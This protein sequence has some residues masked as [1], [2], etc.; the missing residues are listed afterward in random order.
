MGNISLHPRLNS[1]GARLGQYNGVETALSFDDPS[2]ELAA[3]RTQC[4]VFDLSWRAKITVAGKD[5]V[6]WLHNMVT[7]NVRDL[8]LNRGNYNF[9]L[10]VQGRI[11]GDM[12]IYNRGEALLLDTDRTQVATLLTAMKRFI[13]MD[14]VEMTDSSDTF[15]AVGL[16][17]P[18]TEEMLAA[19]GIDAKGLQPLEVRDIT[20]SGLDGNHLLVKGPENKRDWYEIWLS[21]A[22]AQGIWDKLVHAGAQPVGAAALEMWRVMHGIPHYGQDIRDRDLPQETE[23][24]RAL[25]FNK[26]CYIGQE[27][28][29]RIRSRGQVHRK[30]TGFEFEAGLPALGKYESEGRTLAEVTSTARVS[31]S[32]GEKN[33]GL[34]YVRREAAPAGS[35]VDL[36]GHAARIVN[37]P[38][39]I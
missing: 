3:L 15:Q 29:E 7:N 31:V 32:G 6:R 12:Y 13:I 16:C 28:V 20:L 10:N 21:E 19:A 27:I 36:N 4:G 39:D 34:G 30:F 22:N 33:I 35:Q 26:G 23:Q 17:G 38:F 8:A 5:R 11:L 1:P 18:K 2:Q 25:N 14:K 9:V 37:L 24:T